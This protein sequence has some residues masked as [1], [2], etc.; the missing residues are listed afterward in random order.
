MYLMVHERT[1]ETRLA[2]RPPT[3]ARIQTLLHESLSLG[4]LSP[5]RDG[6][7]QH[8]SSRRH[9]HKYYD[10]RP[11]MYRGSVSKG[12][13]EREKKQSGFETA[14]HYVS[15]IRVPSRSESQRNEL[16]DLSCGGDD[17]WLVGDRW[18]FDGMPLNNPT[19]RW[20]P[21]RIYS[22]P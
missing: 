11:F 3:L 22:R 15:S 16:G 21:P 2:P 8:N 1:H 18:A 14:S 6:S 7:L 13:R 9:E 17:F 20:N 5:F 10:R 12:A 4:S 19:V